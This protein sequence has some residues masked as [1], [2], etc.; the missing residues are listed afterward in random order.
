MKLLYPCFKEA[1]LYWFSSVRPSIRLS[2]R[3]SVRNQFFSVFFLGNHASQPL[4]TWYGA[5]A[6]GPTRHLPNSGSPVI[7]F[8][9]Y[10]LVQFSDII[11]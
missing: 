10:D 11:W 7:Y 8:L 9:F 4:K 2:V 1:G 6:R 5:L 3:P